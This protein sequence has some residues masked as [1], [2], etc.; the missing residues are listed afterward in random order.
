[1][2]TGEAQKRRAAINVAMPAI[3]LCGI[4]RGAER[5]DAPADRNGVRNVTAELLG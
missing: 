1:M 4:Q 3:W 2:S 5:R